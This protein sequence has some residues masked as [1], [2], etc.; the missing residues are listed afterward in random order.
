MATRRASS[1]VCAACTWLAL[2]LGARA[3]PALWVARS[4]RAA[5]YLFGTVHVLPSG[6]ANAWTT[7]A[8]D[9]ALA[10]STE[11]WTEADIGSLSGSVAAIRRYGLAPGPGAAELLPPAYRDRFARQAAQA[12]ALRAENQGPIGERLQGTGTVFGA[13]GAAHLG[14]PTGVPAL[15]RRAGFAVT[16]VQ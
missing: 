15:L 16:R 4:P 11:L 13:G 1:A 7:P 2:T 9:R 3:D 14:G 8:I 5:A 12:L 6:A 10:A